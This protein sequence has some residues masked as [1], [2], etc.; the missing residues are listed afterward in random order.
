MMEREFLKLD[1]TPIEKR[2]LSILK[3]YGGK[4][5]EDD[6][7]KLFIS[8]VFQGH[9]LTLDTYLDTLVER[10]EL[11]R[12]R[13]GGYLRMIDLKELDDRLKELRKEVNDYKKRY[14]RFLYGYLASIKRRDVNVVILK[15]CI[16]EVASMVD[17]LDRDRLILG[18]GERRVRRQILLELLVY[19]LKEIID[20]T[21][22]F[23]RR[24]SQRIEEIKGEV[25]MVRESLRKC[26]E[27]VNNLRLVDRTL[28]IK[29]RRLME[30]K[31]KTIK[32][33]EDKTYSREEAVECS[34]SL[35][36]HV[37]SFDDLCERARECLIFDI[38]MIQ[39][40]REYEDLENI[41]ENIKTSL[42]DV[43]G[44]MEDLAEL[45]DS[46]EK[47]EILCLKRENKLSSLIQDWI[48]RYVKGP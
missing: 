1:L 34:L 29:E 8:A 46:L 16:E 47:H 36:E 38:K 30:E 27:S 19:Q 33:L 3:E 24:F 2:I 14:A 35:R 15:D 23:Y 45:R 40:M 37:K 21:E 28:R 26:E 11:E 48:R 12:D 41:A 25:R 20:L 13:K 6:V 5:R 42:D 44:L 7:N 39:M 43:Q 10:R 9:P 18:Y 4:A 22:E 32:E 31:E 17:D